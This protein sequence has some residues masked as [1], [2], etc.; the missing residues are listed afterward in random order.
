VAYVVAAVVL[1]VA[2]TFYPVMAFYTKANE[3]KATPTLDGMA[4]MKSS[5]PDDY[6]AIQWMRQNIRGAPIVAEAIGGEY[7]DYG[8]IATHT[9]I[10]NVLGWPGHEVQW[11]GNAKG[12]EAREGDINRLYATTDVNEAKDLLRKYGIQYVYVGRL[13]RAA[14]AADGKP[15]YDA[16]ALG[17]F[18]TFM[19]AVYQQGGATL[20]RTRN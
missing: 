14:A 10:P 6:N 19:D 5:N 4:Y 17:K 7:S 13:E 8:R 11:R 20:Y 1:I 3:F 16:T 12:W 15:K 2:G 9:G 18:A